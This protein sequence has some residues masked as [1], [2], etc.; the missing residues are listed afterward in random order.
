M[1]YQTENTATTIK[2]RCSTNEYTCDVSG[3]ASGLLYNQIYLTYVALH[4]MSGFILL[5]PL[6]LI[7]CLLSPHKHA[8]E[9]GLPLLLSYQPLQNCRGKSSQ[10]LH[11]R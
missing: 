1:R 7:T 11:L 5:T 10:T 4:V 2:T 6:L 8:Y 9:M 3:I